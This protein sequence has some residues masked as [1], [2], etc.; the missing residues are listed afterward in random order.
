MAVGAEEEIVRAICTDKWD[1]HRFSPSLFRG[2]NTSVSRLA[3]I[4]LDQHWEI[5]R[6]V[7][8]PPQRKLELIG[9]INVGRLQKLGENYVPSARLTVE[10]KPEESNPAHAEIPQ[11]ISEGLSKKIIAALTIHKPPTRVVA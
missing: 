11:K 3:V 9:Q 8:C 5:F 6:C 10:P 4:P 2:T 1:G 7:E